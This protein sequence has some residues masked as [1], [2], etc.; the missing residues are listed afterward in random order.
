MLSDSK[1]KK[2]LGEFSQSEGL[3]IYVHPSKIYVNPGIQVHF[4]RMA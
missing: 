4:S 3:K 2:S 1:M